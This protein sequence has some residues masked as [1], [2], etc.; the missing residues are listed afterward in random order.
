MTIKEP[1]KMNAAMAEECLREY[2]KK[3]NT[4]YKSIVLDIT[5][6]KCQGLKTFIFK[7]L[8]EGACV[9]YEVC[10]SCVCEIRR[11]EIP[12]ADGD[13]QKELQSQKLLFLMTQ[14]QKPYN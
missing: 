7:V 10:P 11:L 9:A 1:L 3:K 13:W 2:L 14:A 4:A 8:S 5:R 6:G 12:Q